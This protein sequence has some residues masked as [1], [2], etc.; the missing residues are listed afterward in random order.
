MNAYFLQSVAVIALC[1]FSCLRAM[2][3]EAK[4]KDLTVLTQAMQAHANRN[5]PAAVLKKDYRD[6]RRLLRAKADPNVKDE[7]G[8]TPLILAAEK[9]DSKCIEF[10]LGKNAAINHQ[11][12]DGNSAIM[13]AVSERKYFS[14]CA[15][16]QKGS[17][18]DCTLK[19][20]NGH[21]VGDLARTRTFRELFEEYAEL[22]MVETITDHQR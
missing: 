18:V 10:L 20:K 13:V 1:S 3:S 12:H 22:L 16:L 11:N 15:L 14:A 7:S 9:N 2:E 6:M 4:S 8:N 21:T 19:N 5:F 17:A